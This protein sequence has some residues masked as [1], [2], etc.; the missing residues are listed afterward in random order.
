M[1]EAI[2]LGSFH[3]PVGCPRPSDGSLLKREHIENWLNNEGK[4][5]GRLKRTSYGT[6]A[7]LFAAAV[8]AIGGFFGLAKD[9]KICKLLGGVLALIGLGVAAAGKLFGYDYDLI[10]KTINRAIFGSSPTIKETPQKHGVP[11]EPV[12]INKNGET[13]M[14]YYLPSPASTNKTVLYLHGRANNIGDCL[15]D[16]VEIQKKLPVNVLM[17]DYRGFGK[18]TLKCEK[19]TPD[20][21]VSDAEAMYDYLITEKG[22]KPDDISLLGHSLGGAVAI[23]LAN[24]KPVNTL[25]VQS[26][27]TKLSDVVKDFKKLP[28]AY[29]PKSIFPKFL[30]D[31]VPDSFIDGLVVD[32]EFNSIEAIKTVKAKNV[33]ISH[34]TKDKVISSDHAEKLHEA[35][36]GSSL[37][38]L[39]GAGHSDYRQFLQPE[40]I[41]L[42]N[43]LFVGENEAPRKTIIVEPPPLTAQ[44]GVA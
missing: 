42:L 17:V 18:S 10:T 15:P 28:N 30:T 25:V 41:A 24:K 31:I 27:F 29:L 19:I 20:G 6:Y 44:S 21:I 11:Y 23:Q 12:A 7:G 37:I 4:D 2:S 39:D 35:K 13:L 36:L 22:C 38:L 3:I 33:V 8:G 32:N 9:N 1:L 26:S 14:G 43:K 5:A 34:G 16:V 40:H